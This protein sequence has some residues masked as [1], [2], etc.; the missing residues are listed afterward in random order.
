MDKEIYE[1]EFDKEKADKIRAKAEMIDKQA[2][3][4]ERLIGN[5]KNDSVKGI[6]AGDQVNDMIISSIRAKLALLDKFNGK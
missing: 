3:K 6:E 5:M 2:K 1:E 4:Q